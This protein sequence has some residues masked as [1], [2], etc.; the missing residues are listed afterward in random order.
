MKIAV[1]LV[2]KRKRL[3]GVQILDTTKLTSDC[4]DCL[5]KRQKTEG[6]YTIA[7]DS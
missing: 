5:S 4:I 3:L 2:E 6:I 7:V 1:M